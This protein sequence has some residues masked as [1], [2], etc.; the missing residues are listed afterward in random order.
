MAN[1]D[2]SGRVP[3]DG[4][5]ALRVAGRE[6]DIRGIHHAVPSGECV[7]LRLLDKQAGATSLESWAW[8][9]GTWRS[10]KES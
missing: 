10:A 3:Q 5:I 6:V 2:I 9:G 4:R 8:R 7:V 1:L